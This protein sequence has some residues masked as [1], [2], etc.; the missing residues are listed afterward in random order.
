ML[1]FEAPTSSDNS[2][3][4]HIVNVNSISYD[5]DILAISLLPANITE[6]HFIFGINKWQLI[7]HI[8]TWASALPKTIHTVRFIWSCQMQ[9][10][11][12]AR[13][14]KEEIK[15]L[16]FQIPFHIKT[17]DASRCGLE[18]LN[19]EDL[20]EIFIYSG[21][22]N[23]PNSKFIINQAVI[24]RNP[25]IFAYQ[26]ANL[27]KRD[28]L[29]L[30]DILGLQVTDM[31]SI[32]ATNIEAFCLKLTQHNLSIALLVQ[33]MIFANLLNPE[34]VN[35]QPD[36][37]K[38]I[39]YLMQAAAYPILERGVALCLWNIC[40]VLLELPGIDPVLANPLKEKIRLNFVRLGIN[41]N[42]LV[43]DEFM[44]ETH[45]TPTV[46]SLSKEIEKLQPQAVPAAPEKTISGY[47]G[48]LMPS[49]LSK[50]PAWDVIDGFGP[51]QDHE[52][53]LVDADINMVLG[54]SDFSQKLEYDSIL[55]HE[56]LNR[57]CTFYWDEHFIVAACKRTEATIQKIELF[58]LKHALARTRAGDANI[59][60]T[61]NVSQATESQLKST[62]L[63]MNRTSPVLDWS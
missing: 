26:I 59:W 4:T 28:N 24:N 8:L 54:M 46:D 52:V 6:I 2:E 20:W 42:T 7:G 3:N 32:N 30:E 51:D 11:L 60:L 36:Y 18:Y 63:S 14:S 35:I 44:R 45:W 16:L 22:F 62:A 10:F 50:L 13:L 53:E 19:D 15:A 9:P 33:G 21:R 37:A 17:I 58:R 47:L 61:Q 39:E 31:P 40:V 27:F 55:F 34:K 43:V 57:S 56:R 25:F 1:Q 41:P 12:P 48:W 38:A 49:W 5:Q 29:T 23:V